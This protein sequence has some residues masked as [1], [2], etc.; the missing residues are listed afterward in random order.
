MIPKFSIVIPAYNEEEGIA[1]TVAAA[2]A[3][4]LPRETFEVI[5]VD[6]NSADKTSE[7]ARTAGADKVVREL[8]KG[9]NFA[10][11]RGRKEA[12]GEIIAFIDGDS[13]PPPDW[14]AHIERDLSE[15]GIVAISGPYDHGF[16]GFKKRA[17]KI[18]HRFVLPNIPRILH[19][20]F[21]RPAGV[22]IGGNF[23]GWN[24]A[25]EKIGGLPP[26][27]FWSDDAATAMLLARHVGN[28]RFDPTLIIK[29]SPRRFEKEGLLTSV[30]RYART[31][32]KIYFAKEYR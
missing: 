28:V 30:I 15:P 31:Y 6:N 23:A 20:L 14:L 29:S 18:Y 2:L 24:W 5:V 8:E 26:L 1:R 10:R 21:R 3:Q 13:E 22:I 32:F 9:T 19:F 25:F 11:E 16:T 27:R 17:D 4:A 7:A 12:Q